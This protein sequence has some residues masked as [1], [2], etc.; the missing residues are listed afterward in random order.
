MLRNELLDGSHVF[1]EA[2]KF[3]TLAKFYVVILWMW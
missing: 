2:Q 1:V 3:E